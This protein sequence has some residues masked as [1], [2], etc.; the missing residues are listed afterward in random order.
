[1]DPLKVSCLLLD[2]GL[3]PL[4]VISGRKALEH[5]FEG[6]AEVLEAYEHIAVRSIRLSLNLP[7]VLRL[8]KPHN[9]RKYIKFS[10]ANIFYRDSMKCAY[11]QRKFGRE[12]LTLDHIL[13][14]CTR[15]PASFK[16]WTNIVTACR[17]CNA[18]KGGRTPEQAG[19]KLHAV[20][21]KPFWSPEMIFPSSLEIPK[22]WLP[23]INWL[24]KR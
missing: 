5:L 9:K 7:A 3:Q 17:K 23:Y 10:R 21:T 18:K 2:V 22:Q 19:M 16:S 14:K 6:K 12:E 20:P 8:F 13:P 24:I 15:T 1:M 11:C 4:D